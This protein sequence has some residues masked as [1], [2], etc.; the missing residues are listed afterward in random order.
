MWHY[1]FW[2]WDIMTGQILSSLQD[3]VYIY[4]EFFKNTLT[5]DRNYTRNYIIWKQVI[6]WS[7][8]AELRYIK[9]QMQQKVGSS[10]QSIAE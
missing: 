1:G 10:F 3:A 6:S 7:A 8:E 5:Y 2:I 9:S 4:F